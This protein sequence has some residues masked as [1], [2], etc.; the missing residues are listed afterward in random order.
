MNNKQ[1]KKLLL[2]TDAVKEKISNTLYKYIPVV[3]KEWI[4][5]LY[6]IVAI[7]QLK[8]LKCCV[9]TNKNLKRDISKAIKRLEMHGG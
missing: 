1:I 8:I 5:D 4:D 7:E 2:S 9:I 6:T 3:H